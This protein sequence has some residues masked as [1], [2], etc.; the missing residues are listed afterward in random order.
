MSGYRENSKNR[1]LFVKWYGEFTDTN[2]HELVQSKHKE[3][4][5][6]IKGYQKAVN[7]IRANKKQKEL[8]VLNGCKRVLIIV[9]DTGTIIALK[10]YYGD[11]RIDRDG[12]L[13]LKSQSE[14]SE[15]KKFNLHGEILENQKLVL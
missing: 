7:I 4:D 13:V 6:L 2:N 14:I 12:K 10:S 15:L 9:Y 1:G 3:N 11:D 5:K 8:I